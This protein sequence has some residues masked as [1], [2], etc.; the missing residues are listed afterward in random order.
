MADKGGPKLKEVTS[1]PEPITGAP[2]STSAATGPDG[3]PVLPGTRTMGWR[4]STTHQRI[5]YQEWPMSTFVANLGFLIGRSLGKSLDD[6]FL[7]P[8]VA[9]KTGLTGK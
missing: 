4:A 6:G 3:F 8:R 2:A 7:Q 5:K 9:N 1:D